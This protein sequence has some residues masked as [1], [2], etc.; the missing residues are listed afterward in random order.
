MKKY[1]ISIVVLLF[2]INCYPQTIKNELANKIQISYKDILELKLQILAIQITSGTYRL[3]EKGRVDY[4]VSINI[5]YPNKIVFGIEKELKKGQSGE[6]QKS[7]IE[8]GFNFV[9]N[10]ITE[11]I[12][13]NYPELN[14]NYEK[15]I[16]GFW[17]DKNTDSSCAKFENGEF[18]W[19]NR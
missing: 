14:I 9:K 12:K 1:L 15:D 17:Y 4:P 5:N 8:E 18:V 11:M 7:T 13:T 19:M 6:A 3:P 16:S 2:C 10:A